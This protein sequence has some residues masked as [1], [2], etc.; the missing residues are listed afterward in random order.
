[1]IHNWPFRYYFIEKLCKNALMR[2]FHFLLWI[3]K[4]LMKYFSNDKQKY[5]QEDVS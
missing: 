2:M 5:Q 3:E 1:M 4:Y